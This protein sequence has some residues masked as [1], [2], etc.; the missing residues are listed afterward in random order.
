M[1]IKLTQKKDD[2][3]PEKERVIKLFGDEYLIGFGIGFAGRDGK[4]MMRF[5][6]NKVKQQEYLRRYCEEEEFID[7]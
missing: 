1:P 3:T 7:D 6:L 5:R 2:Y 4:V